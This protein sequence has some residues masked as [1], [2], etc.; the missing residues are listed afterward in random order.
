SATGE[1]PIKGKDTMAMLMALALNEPI[2][3]LQVRADLP[4]ALS[5]LIMKLLAKERE[6]RPG[7]AKEVVAALKA[8]ERAAATPGDTQ[9][10]SE[11]VLKP[12]MAK[13]M[14]PSVEHATTNPFAKLAKPEASPAKA[15]PAQPKA[16]RRSRGALVPLVAAG[17][18]AAFLLVGCLAAG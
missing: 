11:A 2:P 5:E 4:P 1:L 10:R 18:V 7:T 15:K 13:A 3:P 17:S 14:T 12:P 6:Q 8:I 16:P 9:V